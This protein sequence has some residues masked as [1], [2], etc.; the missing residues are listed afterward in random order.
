LN[1]DQP[2]LTTRVTWN[3]NF[4]NS[5]PYLAKPG[6]P[7]SL[8]FGY[9]FDGLYQYNDFNQLPNGAYV[10]RDDVPNNGLDRSLIKPGY[11]KYK[12]INGDGQVDANDQTYIGNP[13]PVHVGGLSNNFRYKNIDLNIFLQWSY[14]NDILN[15]NRIVFEGA[16][17]RNYLNM[18]KSFENRWTPENTNTDMPAAG[19]SSP[20]VY[21]TRIIEDGS[22]LRLKTVSLGYNL[23]ASTL[24]RIKIKNIRVY[25]AAQNVVTWTS[26][27][28]LDP[29]VSVRN[30][31]LTPG[32]D[33][34]AYP[35]A[36]TIT[37]GLNVTF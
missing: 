35:K 33:W 15:A 37:L 29:E 10:L 23:P 17:G 30:S 11:I 27:S 24:K 18:F 4:N 32:F 5:L 16:E 7:V 36:R 9:L 13:L 1:Y 26:Y 22:F 12:D 3:D 25:A 20:N 6:M 19:V 21:S 28:G 14:G 34:S 2:S 31:A 8:F